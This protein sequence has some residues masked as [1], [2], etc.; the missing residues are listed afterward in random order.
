M[1]KLT[2][3]ALAL[4]LLVAAAWSA[5]TEAQSKSIKEDLEP[6]DK[7]DLKTAASHWG[8]HWGGHHGGWG[9]HWGGYGGYYPYYGSYWGWPYSYYWPHGGYGHHGYWW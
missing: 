4:L 9:G 3:Y 7:D 6:A 1:T 5:P 8:G 2:L